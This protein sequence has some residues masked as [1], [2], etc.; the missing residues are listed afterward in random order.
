M[1][2]SYRASRRLSDLA[3]RAAEQVEEYVEAEAVGTA[4]AIAVDMVESDDVLKTAVEAEVSLDTQANT[5]RK[6]LRE[7][8]GDPFNDAVLAAL[9]DAREAARQ[10]T[11]NRLTEVVGEAVD[12][13]AEVPLDG[14]EATA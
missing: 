12:Y 7:N 14:E 5:R 8:G 11:E 4:E 13:T 6:E 2:V 1:S 3:D 10:A 9:R